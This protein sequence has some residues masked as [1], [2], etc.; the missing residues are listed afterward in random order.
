MAVSTTA[1]AGATAIKRVEMSRPVRLGLEHGV[2][3]HGDDVFDYGCGHGHDVQFLAE[4]GHEA[5]GWDPSHRPDA[6]LRIA[7]VVN[8]GYVLNVIEDPAE[9]AYTLKDAW[10][11]ATRALVI[12]VRTSDE[13]K[14]ITNG[15]EHADGLLTG[16]DTF[17]KLYDQAEARAYID[18]VLDVRT[19]PLAFGV[20][21]AFKDDAAEQEWL[22]NRAALRR[23]VRRLRRIVEARKTL[24]DKA[25]QAHRDILRPLEE[26]IAVR[27]RLPVPG[28]DE[29]GWTKPIVDVFGSL[30]R[31]FQVIRHVA[32][33]P[34]WDDAAD[35]RRQEL[36]VRF[37]LGRLRKR[38]KFTALPEGVRRDV[39]SL[40]S[41]YM[42]ACEQSD[43][44]LFSIGNPD[45]VNQ[46]AVAS[47]IGKRTA[48]AI[49]VHVDAVDLLPAALRV[50]I[51]AA[52]ALVG[53]VPGA[54][55]V[56]AHLAKPR[57]SWLVYPDFDT[58]PHPVLAQSWVVDFREL[59]VRPHDYRGRDNPPVLHRKDLFVAPD[60]P[61]YD[62]FRR[63]TEQEERHGLLDEPFTIGTR[64][65][66]QRRLV[67][68]GWRLAGH[69][70]VRS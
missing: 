3:R 56:K 46:A 55:L 14:F 44:L 64:A 68:G 31:A 42:A 4:L 27:G 23:R 2:I 50:F 51:G 66:W 60:H 69:R 7:A 37:A 29:R 41:S 25:Y 45:T 16:A 63:L 49:Y 1:R 57:V 26:F 21:V 30:P 35:D 54:S 38:P 34:W 40:F 70:L 48:D 62:T 22:D 9:R 33:H 67:E 20:F 18:D 17:Q 39:R 13:T 6:E 61:R 65:G 15:T 58:D 59:D 5:H 11:L 43:D 28:E 8:L 24:R 52:E 36:L 32:Q 19:I 12:A 10:R 47:R 53:D